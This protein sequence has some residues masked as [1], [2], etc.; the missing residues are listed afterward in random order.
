MRRILFSLLAL[1]FC[2]TVIARE[3]NDWIRYSA[4]SPDGENIVFSAKGDLY[5][6]SPKG[7]EAQPITFHEAHEYMPVWSHDGSKLCFASNRHGNFDVFVMD[8]KSGD[9]QRLTYFSKDEVPFSFSA[10]DKY[11]YFGAKRLD[12]AESRKYVTSSQP[13]LYKVP[14]NGGK[15]E[16][17]FNIPAEKV[18][19]NKA[20]TQMIYHDKKGGEN[21]F[22]K[23]HT[24]SVT[25]D[26]WVYN[27][28]KNEHKQISSFQGEE[29]NPVYA[30]GE[31]QIYYLSEESG[32]F[33]VW[34]MDLQNPK[35]KKQITKFKEHPVRFL[36]I[37]NDGLLA[38]THHGD[39][40]TL[41]HGGEPSK[42][43]VTFRPIHKHNA[44]ELIPITGNVKEMAISP[45]GKEVAYTVR[46]EVFV[47]SVD[48]DYTK[49]ITTT[50]G[51]ER[52]VSFSAD[53][54]SVIYA[55]ERDAKWGIYETKRVNKKEDHFFNATLLEENPLIVNEHENYEPVVS[56]DGKEIAY[57]Q[58]KRE[59][60]IYNI[61]SKEIRQIMNGDQ[62]FYMGE[63]DQ[64]FTWSPDS[65][66]L[67]V[68]YSPVLANTEV[69]LIKADGKSKLINLTESGFSDVSPKFVNKGKQII[70]MSNRNGKRAL[71]NSGSSE[72]DVYTMFFDQDAWDRYNLNEDDFELLKEQEKKEKE[73]KDEDK[74]KKKKKKKKDEAKEKELKLDIENARDRKARLTIH[75]SDI[76]DAVLSKDGEKLYYIT[77]FDDK[78]DLWCTNLRTEETKR[79]VRLG[80]RGGGSLEWDKDMENLFLLADG[81]IS[82]IDIAGKSKEGVSIDAEMKLD[83]DAERREMFNHVWKRNKSMFY[84]SDYHGVDWDALRLAYIPKLK[85]INNNFDFTELLSEMLGELNVS[86]SGARYRH[87]TSDRDKTA[88]LGIF[89]DYNYDGDGLKITEIM[90]G[91]PLD[92]KKFNLKKGMIIT[93][94]DGEKITKDVDYAKLL[95]RKSDKFVALHI[96]DPT[97]KKDKKEIDITVKPISLYEESDLLYKRWVKKNEE[98]V[99]RLSDGKMGYVHLPG[100]NDGRYRNTIEKVM[101]KYADKEGLIVD[102]RFNG[103]GDLVGDLT[104][105]LT[106][107]P[108]IDYAIESRSVGMEPGHRWTK[109]SVAM[110]NEANYSD[111]HCFACAYKDLGIGKIIGMPVPGTCSFAGWEMLQNGEVLWGSIPVS[112]KDKNGN[113]MENNQ[114]EPDIKV[115]NIPGSIDKGTDLQLEAAVK[116]LLEM[117]K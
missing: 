90:K 76:D 23:H 107:E 82:K 109:P 116:A 101:G 85:F 88:S 7:G 62:L 93:M 72:Y 14:V 81:R 115:K 110:V 60:M 100:M 20:G 41:K 104:M 58:D 77:R 48:N 70:W 74:D 46:G 117:T 113:W 108:F 87:Y 15:V 2:S 56:P 86:H 94:I 21:E 112:A 102:T 96:V 55:A 59:L 32:T 84:I 52:F 24:S 68:E 29:R 43:N 69:V 12:N 49:R 97:A 80:V 18:Q 30:P 39:L 44:E 75:S 91:G 26:I 114:T 63:G 65:K 40:Y 3:S 89:F 27:K 17:V 95:N 64:Y 16:M 67:L 51:Q 6:V 9:T 92:K 4:I 50:P 10:D 53:G 57:I 28:D 22:R 47:S 105:F 35:K 45:D 66:W 31:K 19:V 5:M 79:L 61:K 8:V 71:A 83:L 11:I 54:K 106:G 34:M 25:R 42:V 36:S 103:G 111:G 13:E 99:A 1:V 33:N 38:F 98:E 37:D 78:G 73:K